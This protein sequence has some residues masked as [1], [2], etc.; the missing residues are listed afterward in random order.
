M[1]MTGRWFNPKTKH[2]F[3][4]KDTFFENN[5][6]RVL[7]NDGIVMDYNMFKDYIQVDNNWTP[8]REVESLGTIDR[9]PPEIA[10]LIEPVSPIRVVDDPIYSPI[11]VPT[12]EPIQENE[13][14]KLVKRVLGR[15]NG[16]KVKLALDWKVPTKQIDT[17][18]DILGVPMEEIIQYYFD[19]LDVNEL[20]DAYKESF[21]N[22]ITPVQPEKTPKAPI[23]PKKTKK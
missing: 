15:V 19:S 10:D 16:P 9:I 2:I 5:E 1:Q 6:F 17:L 11:P 18:V 12:P 23:N 14:R 8:P 22:L 20:I 3:D 7:T 13:D 21:T 4:V